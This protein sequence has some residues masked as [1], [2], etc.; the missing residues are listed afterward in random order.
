MKKRIFQKGL[1][2]LMTAAMTIFSGISAS[3]GELSYEAVEGSTQP[4]FVDVEGGTLAGYSYGG[5]NV[6]KGIQYATAERFEMPQ[7]V[8]PWDGIKQAMRFSEV[9]PQGK[10]TMNPNEFLN[11]CGEMVE[12]EDSCLA[13][14]VWT[15]STD[16]NAK[17]PVLFWIHGGGYSSGASNE[18]QIYDG[19]NLAQYGDV[20][21]VSVNHRLNYLGYMDL[22]AYGEEF[23]YSGNAGMA[24]IICALEWVR[25]NIAQFGG[26]PNNVTIEGQSGGGSK[27]TTL[28]GMP[29]AKGL[30]H[31]AIIQS[32]GSV[33]ATRTTE[34]AQADTKA[35]LDI[36]G[37]KED[38]IEKLQEIDYDVLRAA[39]Q[40]AKVNASPVVDGEY[41]PDGTF[42][43]SADIPIIRST[44]QCEFSSN[45]GGMY[46]G[47]WENED[48]FYQSYLP[49]ISDEEVIKRYEEKYGENYQEIMDAYL[50]AY[51][52]HKAVDG[53]YV[54]PRDNTLV[55]TMEEYGGTAYQCVVAYNF[56]MM[57]GIGAVHTGGDICLFFR[58]TEMCDYWFA[59]E[60]ELADE[61]SKTM[62]NAII[63][64]CRTGN[65][66]QEGLE[67]PAFTE[68]EGATMI[69]DRT[70]EVRNYHDKELMELMSQ[71]QK[72]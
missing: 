6:F 69:F 15:T 14:N 59:G 26:D 71:N 40:E 43:M 23:K 7:K 60:E 2:L 68:E 64:F 5:V 35:V 57:G 33:Q 72:R 50:K 20:V 65:P 29:A 13:L 12:K 37:I 1:A 8:E 54:F 55:E 66:S 38:E 58:N 41:Y 3:A 19:Y 27:V 47:P 56:P 18:L 21:F 24:D 63:N 67:W 39:C 45:S 25:D 48:A 22:S 51:P 53:L 42:K 28:M 52:S 46:M 34:D 32:G 61:V 4:V 31:K 30:F 11:L 49:A 16:P 17:L 36:L 10:T 62:A 9:C 44:V 70:S